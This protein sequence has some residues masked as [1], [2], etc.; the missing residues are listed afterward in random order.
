[1]SLRYAKQIEFHRALFGGAVFPGHG[2]RVNVPGPA[3]VRVVSQGSVS[4]RI[5]MGVA[6]VEWERLCA[7]VM[8]D[9]RVR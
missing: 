4:E 5:R 8:G 9:D 1:M 7:N 2:V 6:M 3:D